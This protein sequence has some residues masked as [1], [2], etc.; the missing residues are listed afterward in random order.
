MLVVCENHHIFALVAKM[1]NQIR[2]H[3]FNVVYAASKLAAL[4]KVVDAHEESF[5]PA[6]TITVLKGIIRR[7]AVTERLRT[8]R[9]R[10]RSGVIPIVVGIRV[11]RRH[12]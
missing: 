11:R 4:A 5:S 12:H 1:L 3:V 10:R 2:R 6:R 7:R 8:S 9:W